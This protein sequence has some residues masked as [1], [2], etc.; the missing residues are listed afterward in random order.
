MILPSLLF[1]FSLSQT[2]RALN[3]CDNE[4]DAKRIQHLTAII[5]NKKVTLQ[6]TIVRDLYIVPRI[7]IRMNRFYVI[8]ALLG[9]FSN[10]FLA[11]I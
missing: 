3:L 9:V 7:N 1:F 11:L 8:D 5:R 4:I 10:Y 6:S 2:L